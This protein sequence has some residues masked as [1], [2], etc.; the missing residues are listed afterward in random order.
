M[1]NILG[2]LSACSRGSFVA[3][4]VLLCKYRSFRSE[5]EKI[6]ERYHTWPSREDGSGARP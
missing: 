6:V 3:A 1:Q 4:G 2:E 5:I